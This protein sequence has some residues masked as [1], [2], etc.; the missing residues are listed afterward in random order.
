MAREYYG[1]PVRKVRVSSLRHGHS[2]D[3]RRQNRGR[4]PRKA[5]PIVYNRH[6][7]VTDGNDRLLG[8]RRKGQTHIDAIYVPDSDVGGCCFRQLVKGK[9]RLAH[10][11]A[12]RWIKM[13]VGLLP[14]PA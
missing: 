6:G 1:Y 8:A 11:L 12:Q 3:D 5:P 7:K 2:P 9:P 14:V 4:D 10:R 13:Q